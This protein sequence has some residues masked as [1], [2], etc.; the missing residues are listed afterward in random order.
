MKNVLFY[1]TFTPALR[2]LLHEKLERI[3]V[4]PNWSLIMDVNRY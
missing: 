2:I 4:I 1:L 3:I